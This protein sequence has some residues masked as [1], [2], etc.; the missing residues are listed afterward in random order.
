MKCRLCSSFPAGT[1][2]K[3]GRAPIRAIS[4]LWDTTLHETQTLQ[5]SPLLE[6]LERGAVAGE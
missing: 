3:G 2:N 6:L 5:W 4:S 1:R